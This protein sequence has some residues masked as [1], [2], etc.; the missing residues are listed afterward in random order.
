MKDNK[1]DLNNQLDAGE[2]EAVAGGEAS[3]W[4]PDQKKALRW[5]VGEV[6]LPDNFY[7]YTINKCSPAEFVK[8]LREVSSS[9]PKADRTICRL[10]RGGW[11][12][13]DES[14]CEDY[15]D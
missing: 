9:R 13:V 12:L 4:D 11:V 8:V 2:L 10:L 15:D 14:D 7:E 5:Y 6:G 3:Q 1:Q